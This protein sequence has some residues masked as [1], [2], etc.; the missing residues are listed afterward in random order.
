M[1]HI[2]AWQAFYAKSYQNLML[3]YVLGMIS[4]EEFDRLT[5]QIWLRKNYV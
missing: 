4:D 1:S 3:Q 5:A 2:K